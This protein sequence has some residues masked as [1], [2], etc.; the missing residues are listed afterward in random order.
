[1][2]GC[3]K[4]DE[5]AGVL[6]LLDKDKNVKNV[7]DHY[8]KPFR[9]ETADIK[10]DTIWDTLVHNAI[11]EVTPGETI[12]DRMANTF[13]KLYGAREALAYEGSAEAIPSTFSRGD[14][15]ISHSIALVELMDAMKGEVNK[16][17]K[18]G[19]PLDKI[20]KDRSPTTPTARLASVIGRAIL[21]KNGIKFGT[22]VKSR[23]SPA[24]I[25]KAYSTIGMNVLKDLEADGY[26]NIQTSNVINDFVDKS[27][28]RVPAMGYGGVDTKL[29]PAE[30]ISL[31]LSKDGEFAQSYGDH[32]IEALASSLFASKDSSITDEYTFDYNFITLPDG[33]EYTSRVQNKEKADQFRDMMSLFAFTSGVKRV[34]V[35]TT[36]V[37]MSLEPETGNASGRDTQVPTTTI[38]EGRD[39]LNNTPMYYKS[40][41]FRF[42]EQFSKE[43]KASKKSL[44]AYI[45]QILKDST[46][47]NILFGLESSDVAP[48]L[49][50]E[51]IRG[52]NISTMNML[53][54]LLQ[55]WDPNLSETTPQ[56][57]S[58]FQ[59][60]NIRLYGENTLGNVQT[61][62]SARDMMTTTQWDSMY[63]DVN[64]EP[65]A[66]A[67]LISHLMDDSGYSEAEI[68]GTKNDK[69]LDKAIVQYEKF[70]DSRTS[71]EDKLNAIGVINTL[72]Y[73][74]FDSI[75]K[76][77]FIH[78]ISVI[79]GIVDVRKG[80]ETGRIETQYMTS[81]DATANGATLNMGDA[82]G[83]NPKLVELL[84]RM[85][86]LK[87]N[88]KP[89]DDSTSLSDIY[90]HVEN[91]I[92]STLDEDNFISSAGKEGPLL[93]AIIENVYKK[94]T[95]NLAKSPTTTLIYKQGPS[96][97]IASISTDVAEAIGLY[98]HRGA[99]VN[100]VKQLADLLG[101][102][103]DK[104]LNV[105]PESISEITDVL[106]RK[107]GIASI[108]Q[109]VMN[110]EFNE[111]LFS[112][113][114]EYSKDVFNILHDTWKEGSTGSK[115]EARTKELRKDI[116]NTKRNITYL[117][118]ANDSSYKE[119]NAGKVTPSEK[120]KIESVIDGRVSEISDL[121]NDISK[122]DK[123]LSTLTTLAKHLKLFTAD[124]FLN[125]TMTA[126]HLAASGLALEKTR[127]VF[128]PSTN[129][130]TMERL[131]AFT[132]WNVSPTHA[133][134]AYSKTKSD[135]AA[136]KKLG[137]DYVGNM[138]VHDM[139]IGNPIDTQASKQPY[140][141]S[142]KEMFE[143][144][145]KLQAGLVTARLYLDTMFNPGENPALE[146]RIEVMEE[147]VKATLDER[148]KILN[149]SNT[150]FI[151][152]DSTLFG[153]DDTKVSAPKVS[154]TAKT[155]REPNAGIKLHTKDSVQRP[156]N[157][158]LQDKMRAASV[159][160]NPSVTIANGDTNSYDLASNTI[161]LAEGATQEQ[162][163]HELIHAATAQK[164]ATDPKYAAKLQKVYDKVK[165]ES[166]G[167]LAD[168]EA[169]PKEEQLHEFMALAISNEA[170]ANDLKGTKSLGTKIIG[171][172]RKLLAEVFGMT[173]KE[174]D[175]AYG[176]TLAIFNQAKYD[177][178]LKSDNVKLQFTPY[179]AKDFRLG[180]GVTNKVTE[181]NLAVYSMLISKVEDAAVSKAKSLDILLDKFPMYQSVKGLL[182]KTY[183]GSQPLQQ[184]MHYINAVDFKANDD[185]NEVLARMQEIHSDRTSRD[186]ELSSQMHKLMKNFNKE[187][188]KVFFDS[189]SKIPLSDFFK[190]S[191]N[192]TTA[193]EVNSRIA[194]LEGKVS[195]KHTK[196]AEAQAAMYI[197]GE[198]RKN[199]VYNLDSIFNDD[200]YGRNIREL[201]ALKS[202]EK[203]G[204]DKVLTMFNNN[205]ELT[206]MVKD[207]V[208]ALDAIY[209]EFG[210][211][212]TKD[213]SVKGTLVGEYYKGTPQTVAITL[214]DRKRYEYEQGSGWKILREP[215]KDKPGIAY[216]VLE[217]TS[218]SEGAGTDIGYL[219]ND[220]FVNKNKI[221][222]GS[223]VINVGTK[224]EPTYK[225]VLTPTEKK[226]MGLIED[227][228][229]TLVKST[230]H[231][232]AA[233][234]S[235]A[236]RDKLLGKAFRDTID[237]NEDSDS[238][239]GI[240]EKID[241]K[242]IDHPWFIKLGD[243]VKYDK[244][245]AKIKANYM[246]IQKNL[247]EIKGFKDEVSLVRKDISHWLVG[248]KNNMLSNYPRLQKVSRY[249]KRLVSMKKIGQVI[250]NPA[251]IAADTESNVLYLATM[252]VP[253]GF[254]ISEGKNITEEYDDLNEAR[255][256]VAKLKVQHIAHPN[257]KRI[258]AEYDSAKDK[259][260]NSKLYEAVEKGYVNSLS[261]DIIHNN[262]DTTE[263]LTSDINDALT[264][265]LKNDKDSYNMLGK[266]ID[267]FSKLGFNG[268]G[269]LTYLGQQ[270][271]RT[272]AGSV[273]GK[274]L[275]DAAKNIASIKEDGDVVSYVTQ[276]L[277]SPNAEIVKTGIF[278]NDLSEITAKVTYDRWLA[279]LVREGKTNKT[280][281]EITQVVLKAFPDYKENL[282]IKDLS[283]YGILMYPS[284]YFRIQIPNY[285]MLV[286]R[287]LSILAGGFIEDATGIQFDT[288]ASGS[289]PVKVNSYG[290]LIHHP[291]E[292][293]SITAE[294]LY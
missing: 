268:E 96:A 18:Y 53:E 117:G 226:T 134:D 32:S 76:P 194:E 175:N 91:L 241:D 101:M 222:D 59:G 94:N 227:G 183:E 110:K 98:L 132:V 48:S 230:S 168:I 161:T 280:S 152:E 157:N 224:A 126:E 219:S 254:I 233:H 289:L 120:R 24:Q 265:L 256:K 210:E 264:Y 70:K 128:H 35:P 185:K 186:S 278:A 52:K 257:D 258:Q 193:A 51:S 294:N 31:N 160:I 14:K 69:T 27:T 291:Y 65:E 273:A 238:I 266:Q 223:N 237:N 221:G 253:A 250:A 282:P 122:Y 195:S 206:D 155:T 124:S 15:M 28:G 125:E 247:S 188:R 169:K 130:V 165:S 176:D 57:T 204:T 145:S 103:H 255:S 156:T 93:E 197:D 198:V 232:I 189:V 150:E 207:N 63:I 149:D 162:I 288:I 56:Y 5:F 26:V 77:S 135:I 16:A 133:Q 38:A 92:S 1:M 180:T 148:H 114:N 209:R 196:L 36:I 164:I 270:M 73:P 10:S 178:K 181:L 236:I 131:P 90:K 216:R 276:F 137:S 39:I 33:T 275:E 49:S 54:D 43:F 158:K 274:R 286:R 83:T 30:T 245:D 3:V 22:H 171:F 78:N 159:R 287:P 269:L 220:I 213:S 205:T 263:G 40:T 58:S 21:A 201:V 187:E 119:L 95:R 244:L 108:L 102:E 80:L 2:S 84:Q 249:T 7:E 50:N 89:V 272:K 259:M 100:D 29:M 214:K 75:K 6:E 293:L 23:I 146:K 147:K 231:M 140:V 144:Y 217:D 285:Q 123:E 127:N 113:Y 8:H 62:K 284:Y 109:G 174:L 246:P 61:S 163:T 261:S 129:V 179:N 277:L 41:M 17:H 115:Y 79:E 74:E 191:P 55:F 262:I 34:V 82:L 104:L 239:D 182:L 166:P 42:L 271:N 243:T 143:N 71:L 251:K 173:T 60:S 118:K 88:G 218:F 234:E 25:E 67:H 281:K 203:I 190:Y 142:M 212:F 9:Y 211:N 215:E 121:Y 105:T 97:A 47:K 112:E 19:I 45:D 177:P 154:K 172:V 139:T 283:D 138:N 4:F 64:S 11:P 225:M 116:G 86:V 260:K 44:P 202:V 13:Y 248:D 267:K 229:S 136:K 66:Y 200:A 20:S 99:K 240:I 199:T 228:V 72:F 85:G 290:G 252:G 107:N 279:Q 242:V 235:Q 37:P 208:L 192:T 292:N 68:L 106:A 81:P 167:M 141:E 170:F 153:E 184:L 46:K 151:V 12:A 87:K 111:D